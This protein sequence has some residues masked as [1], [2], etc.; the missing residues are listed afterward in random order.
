ACE[1]CH[2]PGAKH[3][4][5]GGG[6]GVD[7]FNFGKKVDPKEKSAKCLECHQENKAQV[8][9]S[10]SKHSAAASGVSCDSCHLIMIGKN[11]KFLKKTQPDLCFDCHKDIRV[12]ANKQ[13]HHPIIEGKVLCNDCHDP[14]GELN[15]KMLK[16]ESV[17]D[18]CYKCHAE[19]RGPFMWEHPPV[20]ENCVT[21]HSPHGSN[22]SRLLVMR[23]PEL[24]KDCH[25]GTGHGNA[26][27][28]E[29]ATFGKTTI[30]NYSTMIKTTLRA[31]VNCHINL[32]GSNGPGIYGQRFIR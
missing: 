26:T 7:I 2:G 21:C 12:Q 32:H 15:A 4:E 16:A 3:V 19:K 30:G 8:F 17:N 20:A 6:R 9:W 5:K 14:H 24:C 29:T 25:Q 18:L 22:H 10:N 1:T 11:D 23:V 13:S 28:N 27:Y 31:C